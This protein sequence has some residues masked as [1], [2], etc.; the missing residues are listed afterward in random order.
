MNEEKLLDQTLCREP[1]DFGDGLSNRTFSENLD[2]IVLTEHDKA[3]LLGTAYDHLIALLQSCESR[4]ISF[5]RNYLFLKENKFLYDGNGQT[6]EARRM[7]PFFEEILSQMGAHI[8]SRS[9]HDVL[10]F[11]ENS[12]ARISKI[13][14]KM[15][16]ELTDLSWRERQ[17]EKFDEFSFRQKKTDIDM[18][19]SHLESYI[20][21]KEDHEALTRY[22][23][24]LQNKLTPSGVKYLMW[25]GLERDK[26]EDM[27][28]IFKYMEIE[29]FSLIAFL[30]FSAKNRWVFE[31]PYFVETTGGLLM[32]LFTCISWVPLFYWVNQERG[33]QLAT[34][35][36]AR[37]IGIFLHVI[38]L[39]TFFLTTAH[40]VFF[41]ERSFV[42]RIEVTVAA[43]VSVAILHW[44]ISGKINNWRF[45][46]SEPE[47]QS[48]E[49]RVIQLLT[50]LSFGSTLFSYY[51]DIANKIVIFNSS[52]AIFGYCWLILVLRF[53]TNNSAKVNRS[54]RALIVTSDIE[55]AK[56]SFWVYASLHFT[57][58]P[59]I[60]IWYASLHYFYKLNKEK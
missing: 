32:F 36:Y 16:F 47:K 40:Y 39:F 17:L 54:G 29:V 58:V 30:E 1:L 56:N 55:K 45:F 48:K 22:T 59:T 42:I 8:I 13:E 7:V 4:G 18:R 23:L 9:N 37:L 31:F 21:L 2:Q 28:T 25:I 52:L 50:G 38:T 46:E 11:L 5:G 26:A 44:V 53:T 19:W 15:T 12:K 3:G 6:K 60:F 35:F 20:L 27:W 49:N 51:A 14:T 10:Q 34:L 24:D 57:L 41:L 33:D 43:I